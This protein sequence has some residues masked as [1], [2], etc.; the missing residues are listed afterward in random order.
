MALRIHSSASSWARPMAKAGIKT[1]PWRSRIL[2]AN[3][4]Q[5]P[6]LLGRARRV[7]PVA[8]GAFD[9]QHVRT[10]K[11]SSRHGH[12]G[13][14]ELVPHRQV[15]GKQHARTVFPWS[16]PSI[17]T[18]A[19]PRMWP[20]GNQVAVTPLLR[21]ISIGEPNG[22]GIIF[23]SRLSTAGCGVKRQF[24]LA[25]RA[26]PHD[27]DRIAQQDFHESARRGCGIHRNAGEML[28]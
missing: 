3:N 8:I 14:G 18:A 17:P 7:Q 22:V 5:Q 2:G 24:L 20:A 19:A 16:L 13:D 9:D 6:L 28:M 12:A 10:A 26:R 15:A 11:G 1:L 27:V 21:S 25:L 4:L 23:S